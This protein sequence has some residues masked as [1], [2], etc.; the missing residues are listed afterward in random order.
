MAEPEHN[1]TARPDPE[2][3]TGSDLLRSEIAFW[4]EMIETRCNDMPPDAVE[5]M[6]FALALARKRLAESSDPVKIRG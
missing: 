5:R 3:S 6:R 1:A 2:N 4:Q